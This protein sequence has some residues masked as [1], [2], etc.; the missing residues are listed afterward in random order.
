[1]KLPMPTVNEIY[2]IAERAEAALVNT[3]S[4]SCHKLIVENAIRQALQLVIDKMNI[5]MAPVQLDLGK[6]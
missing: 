4:R 3:T 6:S 5:Q 1:M 2:A